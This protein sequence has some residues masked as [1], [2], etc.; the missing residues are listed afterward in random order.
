MRIRS[1]LEKKFAVGP[2]QRTR[3]RTS[4]VGLM[5]PADGPGGSTSLIVMSVVVTARESNCCQ[6]LSLQRQ[7]DSV[8]VQERELLPA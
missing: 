3:T 1:P 6:V 2:V 4:P 8:C 7:A 5:K